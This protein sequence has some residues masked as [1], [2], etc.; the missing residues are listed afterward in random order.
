MKIS[1][2]SQRGIFVL[3]VNLAVHQSKINSV[4]LQTFLKQVGSFTTSLMSY[5]DQ[6]FV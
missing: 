6:A 4:G 2:T 3:K 1:Q 5:W